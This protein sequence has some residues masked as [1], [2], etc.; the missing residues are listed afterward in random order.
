MM[1]RLLD[2]AIWRPGAPDGVGDLHRGRV[3]ARVPA[4]AGAFVALDGAEGFL[5]D[6]EGGQGLNEGTMWPVRV[7]RA[8]QGG[9]GPRLTARLAPDEPAPARGPARCWSWRDPVHASPLGTPMTPVLVDDAGLR[10]VLGARRWVTVVPRAFDEDIAEAG[11]GAG[12][13]RMSI[14]RAARRLHIHPTP[15][16]VAI[17]VDAGGAWRVGGGKGARIQAPNRAVLPALARQIR[18][19]NLSG[20]ILVD[21]RRAAGAPAGRA[22]ARSARRA[23][24]RTRCARA[25]SASP[26]R[27]GGDRPAARASAAARTAG[28]TAR[29]GAGGAAAGSR[30]LQ[31]DPPDACRRLRGAPGVVAALQADAEA[32]A[33]PCAARRT[34]LDSA[35]D[36]TAGDGV[37][38]GDGRWLKLDDSRLCPICGSPRLPSFARS[39]AAVRGCRSGPLA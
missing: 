14:C 4:M 29:G 28:R 27:P 11:R 21:L 20:A 35:S 10:P 15:A 37:D 25:C 16:L 8:A 34:C 19:R 17:D 33:G 5:P 30:P 31:Q 1:T 6:S 18:L 24:A 3:M 39:A 32:L 26:P 38:A 2:Y 36:P 23:G 22:G 7:T 12:A 9:K 13:A